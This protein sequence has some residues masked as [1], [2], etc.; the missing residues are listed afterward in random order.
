MGGV[1][2]KK[3]YIVNPASKEECKNRCRSGASMINTD[4]YDIDIN[5]DDYDVNRWTFYW[6]SMCHLSID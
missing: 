2:V 5:G 3:R 6:K 1:A 4:A